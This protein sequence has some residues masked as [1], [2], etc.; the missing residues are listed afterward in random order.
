MQ[1]LIKAYIDGELLS[2]HVV[3]VEANADRREMDLLEIR[4]YTRYAD[5]RAQCHMIIVPDRF[6]SIEL[7]LSRFGERSLATVAI[8]DERIVDASFNGTINQR[9]I[10]D[11]RYP[12]LFDGPSILFDFANAFMILGL[13]S[14]EELRA[15]VNV[16]DVRGS[17]L[18]TSFY[19]FR[20]NDAVITISKGADPAD[21]TEITLDDNH[22]GPRMCRS[23]GIVYVFG[24]ESGNG[25]A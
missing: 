20:R 10:A 24:E 5:A 12:V 17:Y 14:G 7:D 19:S 8:D 15:P 2:E 3:S 22:V 1:Q 18:S 11:N 4:N 23:R 9:R 16:I 21:D 6:A 13:S 25:G